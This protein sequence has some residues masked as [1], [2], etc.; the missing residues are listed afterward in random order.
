M[1]AIF[2]A[3]IDSEEVILVPDELT[4]DTVALAH[5]GTLKEHAGWSERDMVALEPASV[6]HPF[7]WT[8]PDDPGP[9]G[10]TVQLSYFDHRAYVERDDT[11][12]V[13]YFTPFI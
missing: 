12:A 4:N 10:L 9:A 6:P 8:L 11:G 3:K 5:V 13:T 1:Q 2:V 7:R